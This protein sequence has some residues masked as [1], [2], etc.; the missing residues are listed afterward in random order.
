MDLPAGFLANLGQRLQKANAILIILKN[1]FPPA[2][3]AHHM[4][5]RPGILNSQLSRHDNEA[6]S[7]LIYVNTIN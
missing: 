1:G 5:N 4:I 2:P 6:T 7:P 3:P